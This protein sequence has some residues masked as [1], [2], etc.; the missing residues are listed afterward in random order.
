TLTK[1]F[2]W[3]RSADTSTSVT[4][5]K[6]M[7]G[8]FIRRWMISLASFR[9]SSRRRATRGTSMISP[10]NSMPRRCPS[11]LLHGDALHHHPG[12]PFHPPGRLREHFVH[13]AV[14]VGHG[15]NA[16]LGPLPQVLGADLGHRDVEAGAQAL[17]QA[18][19][20][21]ALFLEGPAARQVKFHDAHADDH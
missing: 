20:R 7:R 18:R 5:V 6:P 8:S 11:S 3:R 16:Q 1:I 12:I 13:E 21:L 4:V 9:I 15:A 2:T 19:E 17:R 14:A 10:P